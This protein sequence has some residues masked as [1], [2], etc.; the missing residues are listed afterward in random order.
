MKIK[1]VIEYLEKLTLKELDTEH[2]SFVKNRKSILSMSDKRFL[3]TELSKFKKYDIDYIFSV[4]LA[5]SVW[6]P[7]EA[8]T[9]ARKKGVFRYSTRRR[10]KN[11]NVELLL[12]NLKEVSSL[13][14]YSSNTQLFLENKL[15]LSW[16]FNFYKKSEQSIVKIIKERHKKRLFIKKDEAVHEE[17]LFKELLV[18][19]DLYFSDKSFKSM[20]FF[21][22]KLNKNKIKSYE[23]ED[24]FNGISYLIYLYDET[25]GIKENISYTISSDYVFSKDIENLILMSCKINQVEEWEL[26]VDFLDYK[27][28]S[29]DKNT[30][31]YDDTQILE[32]SIR[33]GFIKRDIQEQI[34]YEENVKKHLNIKPIAEYG[35]QITN[36]L[37]KYLINETGSGK[38]SRYRFEFPED[39]LNYF[40]KYQDKYFLEELIEIS[41]N[42]K[43]RTLYSEQ[44]LNKQITEHC[45]IKDI[46]LFQRFFRILNETN[47]KILFQKKDKK[48]IARSLIPHI[49]HNNMSILLS[50]FMNDEIKA[51]ELVNFFTYNDKQK[52]DLQYTPFI[53][54]SNGVFFSNAIVSKSNLLRNCVAHSYSIKNQIVNQDDLE[55]L[56]KESAKIF[57]ERPEIYK[58]FC[59]K[60]FSFEK[61]S[62]E[63]D[64]LIVS[65]EDIII[66]ECKSP[67][68]PTSN[69]EMRSSFDHVSKGVKQL[70]HCKA[71]FMNKSFRKKYLASLKILDKPRNIRTCIIFGN[72]LLNGYSVDGHPIRYIRELDMIVNGGHIHSDFGTW[73]IWDTEDF[74]NNEFIS[75]LS[76]DHPLIISNF[77]AMD[78]REEFMFV[79]DK[80]ISFQ[81]YS[82]NLLKAIASY[83]KLFYSK[84]INHE[85]RET[86]KE[87]SK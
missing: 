7:D 62:G 63:M 71:A 52:F 33:L 60:K 49:T 45:Y 85:L 87:L 19:A 47:Y 80:K 2:I 32:K 51:K 8:I 55:P 12:K 59:N 34:F 23:R 56:V 31:I 76:S 67:L 58:V 44:F 66:V 57:E 64:L 28:I 75:F 29:T 3:L 4:I 17:S 13:F 73:R 65:D 1:E 53:K 27:I 14:S 78:K 70:D 38:L 79:K 83:D 42:S 37:G 72:R 39:L 15:S 61:K 10:N 43:E 54:A 30:M 77:E 16:L 81:T 9:E 36:R 26:N 74:T 25:I 50:R 86:V 46:V 35:N 69:F 82:F 22:I 68:T 40:S 41:Y 11:N 5:Y 84:Y 48:K 24:I 20:D 18:Y 21:D 6:C